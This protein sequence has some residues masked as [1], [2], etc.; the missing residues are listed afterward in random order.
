MNSKKALPA[1]PQLSAF[2][3]LY[4]DIEGEFLLPPNY[5]GH[6][7]KW[8]ALDAGLSICELC[9]AD[10]VCFRGQCP[11]VQMEQSELVCSI[12]GCVIVLSELKAEWGALDRV[13]DDKASDTRGR[14]LLWRRPITKTKKGDNIHDVV[15]LVVRDILDSHKTAK[16]ISEE[17]SRDQARKMSCLAKIIREMANENMMMRVR[18]RPN[19]L[20]L[21]AKLFWHCRKCRA[22]PSSQVMLCVSSYTPFLIVLVTP[23]QAIQGRCPAACDRDL[24]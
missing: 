8:V 17:A 19:M 1:P 23:G 14:Q 9:G 18:E 12:S 4:T 15:E 13:H 10:H 11:T 21:E 3:K 22:A 20:V 16:C 6:E 7:Y 5:P 24:C 2:K